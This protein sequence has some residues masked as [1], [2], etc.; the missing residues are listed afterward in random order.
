VTVSWTSE[1]TSKIYTNGVLRTSR[2]ISA[3][4]ATNPTATGRIG[5]GHEAPASWNG[6][7][8]VT[9]IYNRQLTDSE[10]LSNFNAL[11]GRYNV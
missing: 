8:G 1:G 11:R 3:I 10:I 7:I 4:P 6:K 9:Q 2:S 5:L